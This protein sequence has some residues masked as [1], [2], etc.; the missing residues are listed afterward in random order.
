MLDNMAY[1]LME[2]TTVLS[3]GLYRYEQFK[4]DAREC[5]PC[6]KI[7]DEMKRT[8]EQQLE[9]LLGHLREHFDKL[10]KSKAA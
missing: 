4:Q 8:D 7:W 9:R 1:N 5:P 2:A 3:K 10:A 6:Q